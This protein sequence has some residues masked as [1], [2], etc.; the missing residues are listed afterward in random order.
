MSIHK[1]DYI[2]LFEKF[3]IDKKFSIKNQNYLNKI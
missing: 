3:Q 1:I 2:F